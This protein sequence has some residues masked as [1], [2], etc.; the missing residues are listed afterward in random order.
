VSLG[1]FNLFGPLQEVKN[2]VNAIT[3]INVLVLFQKSICCLHSLII[4]NRRNIIAI[5]MKTTPDNS[6]VI[7]GA[8]IDR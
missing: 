4:R 3:N 5:R 6:C 1:H 8:V 7:D 2:D